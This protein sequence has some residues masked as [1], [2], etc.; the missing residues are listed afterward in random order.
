MQQDLQDPTT[1]IPQRLNKQTQ[2]WIQEALV[3]ETT[4]TSLPYTVVSST[5][6]YEIRDYPAY[7][8]VST[9]M[10]DKGAAWNT[11]WAYLMG[12]NQDSQTLRPTS[13]ICTTYTGELRFYLEGSAPEPLDPG[14]VYETDAVRL[15][16]IPAARLAVRRFT[17]FVTDGEVQLQKQALLAALELD[18]VELDV[19]HGQPVGHLVLEYNPPYA[20][21]V[22]RRNELAVPVLAVEEESW[23]VDDEDGWESAP[24]D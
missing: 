7:T 21:P 10:G 14:Q 11:L 2:D 19:P 5:K 3:G 12:A 4:R 8:V 16:L 6:N 18:D 17:G 13:P 24:S 20:I 9:Q 22:V 15:E 1:R 23:V